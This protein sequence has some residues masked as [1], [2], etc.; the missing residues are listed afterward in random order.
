MVA[1]IMLPAVL[2]LTLII[3]FSETVA[4][5]Q[6]QAGP[7][8]ESLVP[9]RSALELIASDGAAWVE[10]QLVTNPDNYEIEFAAMPGVTV[11]RGFA[12]GTVNL[13]GAPLG[14][15][16]STTLSDELSMAVGSR[17]SMQF[18]RTQHQTR[19][20]MYAIHA[21][22][23]SRALSL[24]HGF[25]GG[26]T[27]GKLNL[28]REEV[29][30]R[31]ARGRYERMT[32]HALGLETGLGSGFSLA[33]AF[34][35]KR[36]DDPYGLHRTEMSGSLGMPLAGSSAT[37]AFAK[38]TQTQGISRQ[39]TTQTDLV[40]P[41]RLFGGSAA[42]EHHISS[43]IKDAARA[44]VKATKFSTPL[45]YHD[46]AF[47]GELTTWHHNQ[48]SGLRG[49]QVA[50][51]FT[52]PAFGKQWLF[53]Y[54]KLLQTQ[55]SHLTRQAGVDIV[56]PVPLFSEEALF[57][58]HSHFGGKDGAWDLART[59]QIALPLGLL[60][61]GATLDYLN[62]RTMKPG[63]DNIEN[64]TTR[65]YLPLEELRKGATFEIVDV[66]KRKNAD[67]VRERTSKFFS[68]L[69]D[70]RSGA[71]LE[72]VIYT[73]QHGSDAKEARTTTFA[74]PL[75]FF[76]SPGHSQYRMVS[77]RHGSTYQSEDILNLSAA[78]S[79]E[80]ISL[81]QKYIDT[82]GGEGWQRQKITFIKSPQWQLF[83]PKA[84]ISADHLRHEWVSG[85]LNKTTNLALMAHL[86]DPLTLSANYK[87]IDASGNRTEVTKLY[88]E[89]S[90]SKS[91]QFAAHMEATD[92]YNALST[93]RRHVYITRSRA[94]SSGL[95]LKAGLTS[96][97]QP[98]GDQGPAG[99]LQVQWG[100]PKVLG[101]NAQYA[102]YDTAKWV[103][104]GEPTVKLALL[105]GEP[106]SLYLKFAYED[107]QSRTAQRRGVEL[108]LPVLGSDF[109]LG[110][111]ENPFQTDG[112][113][114]RPA[115]LYDAGIT[116]SVF[117]DVD[118]KMTYRYCD[119]LQPTAP[120]DV[121][122]YVKLELA[123]GKAQRGG[124]IALA[125]MSG[126]FVPQP[127][128]KKPPAT[129]IF[130][131]SYTKRWKDSARLTLGLRRS[132]PPLNQPDT[133]NSLEGR[134]EYDAIFW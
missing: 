64:R 62:T 120:E 61:K 96:W 132:T 6:D 74:M 82:F 111:S 53:D 56:M 104:L 128:P 84:T 119:Y 99:I 27:A 79:G 34:R 69:D 107:N 102:E 45:P 115:R 113:T 114:I 100:N 103:P 101:I 50:G 55:S 90:I 129:S 40:T 91:L 3:V 93:I 35:E 97:H 112:K 80:T 126:D 123:G 30:T 66:G 71:R 63:K 42:F 60:Q 133:D 76:G 124:Q 70:L 7:R 73:F 38:T 65:F 121:A 43:N 131:L 2:V 108:A 5:A 75:K 23:E 31:A 28:Q 134:L 18:S 83:T 47:S 25:G 86:W 118:M 44:K 89:Y 94:G 33:T 19:D 117:G 8:L 109:T 13:K 130:D 72:Y 49:R 67:V 54:S 32:S 24:L 14:I 116:R 127:D 16:I 95:D 1:R 59:T 87:L 37:M 58:R 81:E 125:Y 11:K 4:L 110:F 20:A 41:M 88:S 85:S 15:G 22:S 98:G 9:T 26:E 29:F 78:L 21:G 48:S 122:Q 10:G 51:K 52:T 106:S 39:E 92:P 57:E 68:P 17:T 77:T 105:H 12:E 36:S 46:A